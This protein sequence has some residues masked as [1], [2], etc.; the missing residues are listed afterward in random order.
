MK[1]ILQCVFAAVFLLLTSGCDTIREAW[2]ES[3]NSS[4]G[5]IGRGGDW[6]TEEYKPKYLFA[7]YAQV[8][9]PRG[10]RDLE[11]QIVTF[12]GKRLWINTNQFLSSRHV[13]EIRKMP[14]ADVPGAYDLALKL[15]DSG[16][17]IWTM[18]AQQF[19]RDPMIMM[20][21]DYYQCSFCPQPLADVDTNWVVISYPFDEVTA[22]GMEK[23]AGKNFKHLSPPAN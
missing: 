2:E 1:K 16:A 11:R 12:E 18:L 13:Q 19:N 9:Y 20:I 17:R 6:F 8:K 14:R 10:L 3:M 7:L 23:Y 21:D 22:K 15:S 5:S 4:G